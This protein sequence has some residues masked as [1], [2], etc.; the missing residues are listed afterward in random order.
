MEAITQLPSGE[1]CAGAV[2]ARRPRALYARGRSEATSLAR[3]RAQLETRLRDGRGTAARATE[4]FSQPDDWEIR[5]PENI[6]Q[7]VTHPSHMRAARTKDEGPERR[8]GR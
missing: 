5:F 6:S 1:L 2:K 7:S 3:R 8:R 4:V